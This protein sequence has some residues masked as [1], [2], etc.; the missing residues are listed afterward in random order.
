[1]ASGRTHDIAGVFA[2]AALSA[3]LSPNLQTGAIT[4]YA[5]SLLV[6]GNVIGYSH[7]SPDLDLPQSRPSQRWGLLRFT[8]SPY[9]RVMPHRGLSHVPILGSL[10]RLCYLA[11][12]IAAIAWLSGYTDLGIW[13]QSALLFWIG[14]EIACL[15]HLVFD[16]TPFLRRL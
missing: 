1:M 15:V 8:W 9:Q 10:T 16:Y 5:F 7:L 11:T 2:V 3:V 12:P 13:R 6:G 14:V 4:P